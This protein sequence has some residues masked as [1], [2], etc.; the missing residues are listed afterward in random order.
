MT[1]EPP[2]VAVDEAGLPKVKVYVL[3]LTTVTV[4][5]PF[6]VIPPTEEGPV[7]VT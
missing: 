5:V 7:M 1:A 3:A 6:G 4:K 2:P